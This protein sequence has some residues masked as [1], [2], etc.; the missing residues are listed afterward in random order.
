M[1][2]QFWFIKE[3]HDIFLTDI[4]GT[5]RIVDT[6]IKK[7]KQNKQLIRLHFLLHVVTHTLTQ[8]RNR[9]F[10]WHTWSNKEP[11]WMVILMQNLFPISQR[12]T[13]CTSSIVEY[14]TVCSINPIGWKE[15]HHHKINIINNRQILKKK[16]FCQLWRNTVTKGWSKVKKLTAV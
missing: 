5:L 15:W 12:D 14:G 3:T 16:L 13:T 2:A 10:T 8:W 6:D 11:S 7:K 4:T 9:L 1:T